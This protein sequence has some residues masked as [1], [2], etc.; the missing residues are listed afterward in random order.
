MCS[1]SEVV[2]GFLLYEGRTIYNASDQFVFCVY[3][4]FVDFSFHPSPQTKNLKEYAPTS[5]NC[6]FT[7]TKNWTDVYLKLF[8][9]NSPYYH[10]LKYLL[11]LLKHPVYIRPD[12]FLFFVI[13]NSKF[14][15]G[16][17]PCDS[18]YP[19][20]NSYLI[21]WLESRVDRLCLWFFNT[22]NAELNLI[23]HLLALLGAHHI[24]HFS[25]IRVKVSPRVITLYSVT[26]TSVFPTYKIIFHVYPL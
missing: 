11:F 19:S 16:T 21:Y 3:I 4:F 15:L 22:L 25:R 12:Y 8:T 7:P 24:L 6:I 5:K 13:N 1:S 17:F 26:S 2:L 9:R 23:C 20:R 14:S 10:L 18:K